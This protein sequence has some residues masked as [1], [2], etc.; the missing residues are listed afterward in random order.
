[1]FYNKIDKPCLYNTTYIC[2]LSQLMTV[3]FFI[4]KPVIAYVDYR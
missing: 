3:Y 1:M 4:R 2:Q